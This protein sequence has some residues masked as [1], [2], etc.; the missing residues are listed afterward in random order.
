MI[1]VAH[2]TKRTTAAG[3]ENDGVIRTRV[4]D[5]VGT[6]VDKR[7]NFAV[8]GTI[9]SAY[10]E[11]TYQEFKNE[12]LLS[13]SSEKIGSDAR[14]IIE[15]NEFYDS[16]LTGDNVPKE[17]FL[18]Y[19][20]NGNAAD[21]LDSTAAQTFTPQNPLY[22]LWSSGGTPASP[23]VALN[24]TNQNTKLASEY[25]RLGS[26]SARREY[27]KTKLIDII[28]DP[29]LLFIIMGTTLQSSYV[30]K[31]TQIDPTSSLVID[32]IQDLD[33]PRR[34]Q[35]F[36]FRLEMLTRAIS[37][38]S[39]LNDERKFNLLDGEIS[40][41]SGTVFAKIDRG[42]GSL[43]F[44]RSQPRTGWQFM[45]LGSVA[46]TSPFTY[47]PPASNISSWSGTQDIATI[48]I[49]TGVPQSVTNN[50]LLWLRS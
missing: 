26:V 19:P 4:E 43:I 36:G 15:I 11:G 8:D 23:T 12:P 39:N 46:A 31:S 16:S 49:Q 24:P 9:T 34:L 5:P 13:V 38:D 28:S 27:F 1:P 42:L 35:S 40:L 41:D 14:F 17:R 48:E 25:T 22:V 7:F 37:V 21:Y 32:I 50:W 45:R 47:T 3:I 44:N 20:Y 30:Q 2:S 18:W 33:H 10:P 6:V 29:M